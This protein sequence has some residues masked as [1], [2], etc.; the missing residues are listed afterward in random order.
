LKYLLTGGT[1]YVGNALVSR[2][3]ASGNSVA[4]IGRRTHLDERV[5]NFDISYCFSSILNEF[6]P[7][8]II[9][10]AA[11][12]GKKGLDELISVNLMTPLKLLEANTNTVQARFI[13]IGSYWQL[14]DLGLPGV[15]IDL[16]S[17]SKKSFESFLDYYS[18]YKGI[19]CIQL[20]L[21]GT[22]G[23]FDH[24]G[25]LLDYLLDSVKINKLVELTPGEQ[26][27]NLL[28]ILDVVDEIIKIS[29]QKGEYD[30][31]CRSIRSDRDYSVKDL[32]K[33]ISTFK[34][35]KADFSAAEYREVELMT[36]IYNADD[37]IIKDGLHEYL[38]FHFDKEVNE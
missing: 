38:K 20:T 8:V 4:N 30:F 28:Y 35:L 32:V 9:H 13:T 12:F 1:G 26:K 37:I 14:G 10:I 25:K 19:D 18:V 17:A 21:Y 27:L 23:K 24:R 15:P 36:P 31:R 29:K 7:D 34:Y 16:Y 2:L 3:L 22:Y 5:I 6:E 11:S 33:I